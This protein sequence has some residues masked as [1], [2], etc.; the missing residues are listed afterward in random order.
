M[1]FY[2][3]VIIL[4]FGFLINFVLLTKQVKTIRNEGKPYGVIEVGL[5]SLF[6]GFI[7]TWFFYIYKEIRD[8]DRENKY[9]LLIMSFVSLVVDALIIFLIIYFGL[10]T[11]E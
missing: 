5:C 1:P 8:F 3:L 2:G 7:S 6:F 9:F 11:F 4:V 10:I